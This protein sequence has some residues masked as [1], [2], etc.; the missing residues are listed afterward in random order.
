MARLFGIISKS[1]F[2]LALAI[3]PVTPIG[4][5]THGWG[6]GWYDPMGK[7]HIQKGKRSAADT[8]RNQPISLALTSYL[9]ISHIR[10]ASSGQVTE[11]NA[12]PF[13]FKGW[14]FAH[15]GSIHQ[16]KIYSLLKSPYN[17]SFQSQP[18]DSEVYFRFIL[19][20]M[21]E[22]GE[23]KGIKQAVHEAN[24]KQGATFILSDGS[25]LYAYSYGV[26]LYWLLWKGQKPFS[27]KAEKTGALYQSSHL[28]SM[29][30]LVVASERLTND[31]WMMMDHG[32]LFIA[33]K[34]LQYQTLRAI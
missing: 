29:Q 13:E 14:V 32:E 8:L 25:S 20:S 11:E 10:F 24:N 1:S 21:K 12:H 19:Q 2:D 17:Q 31:N 18:I 22:L 3:P 33:R 15:S 27:A 34:S 6:I 4:Q 28:V 7:P 16:E 23:T 26:P 9:V 5:G 30:A